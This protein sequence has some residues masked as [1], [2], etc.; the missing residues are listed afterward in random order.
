MRTFAITKLVQLHDKELGKL[1]EIEEHGYVFSY[2]G[3]DE[4]EDLCQS[5]CFKGL[6]SEDNDGRVSINHFGK[7]VLAQTR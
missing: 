4:H 5:L 7:Q 1:K 3:E 2:D 6:C